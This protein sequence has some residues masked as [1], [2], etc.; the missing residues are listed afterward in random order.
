MLTARKCHR[1]CSLCHSL[2]LVIPPSIITQHGRDCPD[3]AD[4]HA[5]VQ[6]SITHMSAMRLPDPSTHTPFTARFSASSRVRGPG[7][8]QL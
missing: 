8:M 3:P 6:L 4:A 2:Q 7:P 5:H 1:L